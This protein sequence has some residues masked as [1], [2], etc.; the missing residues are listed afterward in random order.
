MNYLL[1]FLVTIL[2]NGNFTVK[3]NTINYGETRKRINITK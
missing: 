2:Q 3:N 1:L